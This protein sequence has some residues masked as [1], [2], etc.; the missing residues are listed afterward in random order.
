MLVRN[1]R[2]GIG[3]VGQEVEDHWV[4]CEVGHGKR[5]VPTAQS[6]EALSSIRV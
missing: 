6:R 1:R 3:V 2:V 5:E 4:D